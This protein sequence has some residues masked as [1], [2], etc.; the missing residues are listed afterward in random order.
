MKFEVGDM[1]WIG[2]GTS[3]LV[4]DPSLQFDPRLKQGTILSSA[5]NIMDGIYYDVEVSGDPRVWGIAEEH[6][7]K[8]P[9]DEEEHG[10]KNE[11][12]NERPAEAV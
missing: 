12:K 7:Y 1:V 6:L 9:P 11:N 8:I 10:R 4:D 3:D 2:W 5:Y